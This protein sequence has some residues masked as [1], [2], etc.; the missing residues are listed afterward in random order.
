VNDIDAVQR[1]LLDE[2]VGIPKDR[3]RR[4]AA[5]HPGNAHDATVNSE[6]A[7]LANICAALEA[8]GSERVKPDDRVFIYYS[9]HGAR[10]K[11]A[12]TEGR[13]DREALV[14]VDFD[15]QPGSLR[16]L[17]DF[18]LNRLLAA[19][20]ARTSAVSFILDCCHSAGATREIGDTEMTPRFIDLRLDPQWAQPISIPPGERALTASGIRGVAGNIED[21]QVIAACLN[22]ELAQETAGSDGVRHGLL[23]RALVE[24]LKTLPE[25]NL[26]AVPWGRI[27]QGLRNSVE[28]RNPT[29][30]VWMAGSEAREVLAGPPIDADLGLTIS[31]K[32]AANEYTIDAGTLAGITKGAKIA[33]YKPAPPAHFPPL[34]SDQDTQARCSNVLLEV[35]DAS[36]GSATAVANG[37]LDLPPGA[38]GRLVAPGLPDRLRC[39]VV[40]PA[41]ADADMRAKRD[42]VVRVL[43]SSP[44]IEVVEEKLAQALLKA[45]DGSWDL[46]DDVHGAK[47]DY[48][49]LCKLTADQFD[50]AA[51]VMEQYFYYWLPLRM[52]NSC[53][54]LP[55][56]LQVSV[57]RCPR[58]R[59]LTDDERSGTGL[60]EVGSG[61]EFTYDLKA[62]ELLA[63]RLRNRS[64]A[65]L[66]VTL[67]NAAASGRVEYLGDQIIDG[68]AYYMFWRGNTIGA[69]FEAST[70]GAAQGID[71][72]VAIG[73][74]ETGKDLKYLKVD[75][76]FTEILQRS[77]GGVAKDLGDTDA[78]SPPVERWTA[79]QV[80]MRCRA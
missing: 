10:T 40:I 46:V 14:P 2:R 64:E 13:Y 48:P 33:V 43:T 17:F 15:A 67:L 1:L 9:G 44:L 63:I 72:L 19:I 53:K 3:I 32:A 66:R 24:Q 70:S 68:G 36:R 38:R 8:L 26:R 50:L 57:L 74:T 61:G 51:A 79:S 4:L 21:C 7:T 11:V 56:A 59:A 45:Q 49:A 69:P 12:T 31:R 47:P 65:R 75:S 62:G 6:P 34:G 76:K 80:V 78:G 73:T 60:P 37:V 5:P 58:D 27:W 55:G 16:L 42:A 22:H 30:H 28:T 54:D 29:Q 39:A 77:R 18:D 41:T 35:V 20:A 25:N 52:A 71:R 23:T